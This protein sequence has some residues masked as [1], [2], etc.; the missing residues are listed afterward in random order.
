MQADPVASSNLIL[1]ASGLALIAG[2]IVSLLITR[3]ITR[4]CAQ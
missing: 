3:L 4:H 2:V 1:I